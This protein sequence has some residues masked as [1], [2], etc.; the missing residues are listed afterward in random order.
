MSLI[1]QAAQRLEQ[2]RRAG[3]DIPEDA[4]PVQPQ[5]VAVDIETAPLA[6]P[7]EAAKALS[8]TDKTVANEQPESAALSKFVNVDLER[9]SAAGIIASNTTRSQ[10]ADEF[11]LIKRPLIANALGK[12]AAPV[13][14][15]N[16]IMVT[17]A[18]PA[19]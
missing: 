9:L 5:T 2:L 3:V 14:N 8:A 4:P 12:G 15:G 13:K 10:L 16:L 19:P 18:L 7:K 6:T 1:E 17:S 11:R